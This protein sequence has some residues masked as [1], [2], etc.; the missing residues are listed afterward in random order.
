MTAPR[1]PLCSSPTL[2][3]VICVSARSSAARSMTGFGSRA[4]NWYV[5]R[6]LSGRTAP[7]LSGPPGW[8]AP[9]FRGHHPVRPGPAHLRRVPRRL[10]RR[11]VRGRPA[12][13]VRCAPSLCPTLVG[14]LL[15]G[16]I[17]GL[18]ADRFGSYVPAYALF[19]LCSGRLTGHHP[20]GLPKAGR[21]DRPA[22]PGF[23]RAHLPQHHRGGRGGVQGLAP[24]PHGDLQ[25]PLAR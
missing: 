15:F 20:A 2:G 6:D 21:S 11:P 8:D 10:G 7:V 9:R 18:L 1:R 16:P 3:L 23:S 12:T 19:A 22:P 25:G 5:L 17:P 13:R 24:R 14:M 4:G